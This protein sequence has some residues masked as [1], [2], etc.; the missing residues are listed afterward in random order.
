MDGPVERE[1]VPLHLAGEESHDIDEAL[2]RVIVDEP[3]FWEM[4]GSL[5][6]ALHPNIYEEAYRMAAIKGK[7]GDLDLR[8]FIEKVGLAK[9]LKL[10]E[11]GGLIDT[12][13]PRKVVK[14]L[15]IERILANLSAEE[16]QKLKERLN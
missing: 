9:I 4:Y 12:V 3:G 5:L 7:R 11:V 8:P 16:R 15:G 2:A 1:S 13:G 6:G 10:V 14:G